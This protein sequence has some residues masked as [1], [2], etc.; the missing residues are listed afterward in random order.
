MSEIKILCNIDNAKEVETEERDLFVKGILEEMGVPLEEVWPE[1]HLNLEQ[2]IQLRKLLG[3]FNIIILDNRDG[4]MEIYV[5]NYKVATWH[6]PRYILKTDRKA[7]ERT[8]KLYYEMI[9]KAESV[10]EEKVE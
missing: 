1:T 2:K 5:D 7:I 9:L 6:K 10:F 8:K 3:K 4:S